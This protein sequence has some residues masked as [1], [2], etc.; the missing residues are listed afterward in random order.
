MDREEVDEVLA[1]RGAESDRIA[2]S[3]L[4]MDDDPGHAL[5]DDAEREATW[6][7]LERNWPGYRKYEVT[8][9]RTL[10]VFRLTPR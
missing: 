4:A 3:L 9:G 6:P 5:L 2:Q 10:R 7:K 8:A 1:V